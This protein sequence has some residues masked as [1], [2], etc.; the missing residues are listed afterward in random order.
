MTLAAVSTAAPPKVAPA[1][2]EV[3]LSGTT[4]VACIGLVCYKLFLTTVI[5]VNWDEFYF[6]NFIHAQARGELSILMQG[7]YTHLFQWLPTLGGDEMTQ[8]VAGRLVMVG[9]LAVT[10][11]LIWRLARVW[12]SGFP[13]LV[14]PFLYLGSTSVMIHGGSFRADS[15]LAPLLLAASVLISRPTSNRR[16]DWYAG[17]LI[18]LALVV[19][20]KAALFGPLFA[21]LIMSRRRPDGVPSGIDSRE[22]ACSLLKVSAAA[23]STATLLLWLHSLSLAPVLA[24]SI[25]TFSTRV[26]RATLVESPL[27]ARWIFM[28][29]YVLW[30]PLP[31]ALMAIGTAAA[32]LKRRFDLASLSLSLLPIALYR[33]A[34]PYYYVVMLAP[35][36]VLAGFAVQEIPAYLRRY[37]N[38]R[39]PAALVVVIWLGLTY[40]SLAYVGRLRYDDQELQRT[41]VSGVH[42][43]FPAPVSYIDRCG[44]ISSF[45][46]ANFFMSTW[47]MQNYWSRGEPFM[48]RALRKSRP[49]FVLMNVDA[50]NPDRQHGRGL[51]PEDRD[52]I[53]KFY[54]RYWGPVRVAGASVL[55]PRSIE[56]QVRVPF[57]D[58]YRLEVPEP[59]LVDG[60]RC[61]NGDIIRVSNRGVRIRTLAD[62]G[63]RDAVAVKLFIATSHARPN[64][65]P[66]VMPLFSGL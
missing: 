63:E 23:A 27:F 11:M 37:T 50:L 16:S 34:F 59:V 51:L 25:G 13:A 1:W 65:S 42:A 47:G 21:C 28:K 26:A 64:P 45:R 2:L 29:Q 40:Q 57:E 22:A 24:E 5:N 31:W 56:T 32:L 46:K 19:T 15:L 9:L 44:M 52:L 49:A 20:V 66:A 3:A 14:A 18:G 4:I 41:V 35:A 61:Q 54:P 10:A 55:I 12:L 39:S 48:P 33:N 38:G 43:I 53:A 58:D 36:S 30:Q 6:L 8:I 7:A 60:V 62:S 17:C